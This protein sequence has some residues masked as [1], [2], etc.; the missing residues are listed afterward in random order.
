M[1]CSAVVVR[2]WACVGLCRLAGNTNIVVSFD[3]IFFLLALNE[4]CFSHVP[5]G[6]KRE[7]NRG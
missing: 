7:E 2:F 4:W 6:G 3:C 5:G 1:E